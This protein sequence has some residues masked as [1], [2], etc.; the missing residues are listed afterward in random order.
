[1]EVKRNSF[2]VSAYKDT[3]IYSSFEEFADAVTSD[4]AYDLK[5]FYFLILFIDLIYVFVCILCSPHAVM[6]G[7]PAAFHGST[8]PGADLEIRVMNRFPNAALFVEKPISA[9]PVPST[10]E[11]AQAI[12]DRKVVCSV[13]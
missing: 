9:S 6:V 12:E 10:L 5:S 3:L 4:T 2:V 7:S 13:G 8:E 11:V 1:M